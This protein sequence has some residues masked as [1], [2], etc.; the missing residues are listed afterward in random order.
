MKVKQKFALQY[1]RARLKILSLVSPRK[2]A[3][4]AFWFF[5]T[6][7]QKAP[8]RASAVF[9]EGEPLSFRLQGHTVRGHRWLP[10]PTEPPLKKVLIVHGFE[11]T[12]RNFD[13]YVGAF[14]KKGYEVLAFDAPAHGASG[15]KRISLPL[16]V[17]MLATI[18]QNYGPIHSFM[19][20][21]LGGLALALYLEK[22][23]HEEEVRLVLIAPAVEMTKAVDAF[24]QSMQLPPEVRTELD[25]YI[26]EFS[27]HPFSWFS[28]RRALF[29]VRARILYLQDEEDSVTPLEDA[30]AVKKDGHPGIRFVFT[31]GLGHRKIYKDPEMQ[32]QIVGF[33]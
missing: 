16:Y 32:Q 12:A 2:A 5:G 9:D 19:G 29:G 27:G 7:Q 6:P 4:K 20:H 18:V 11:S 15:G 1:I 3:I 13:A 24:S 10:H 17:E 21:S 33:L 8:H 22:T 30:L 25:E 26:Q 28:L 14:L 23:P 31:K